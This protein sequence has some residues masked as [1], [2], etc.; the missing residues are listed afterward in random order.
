MAGKIVMAGK[1]LR[2]APWPAPSSM[3]SRRR[4]PMLACMFGRVVAMYWA[5]HGDRAGDP[6]FG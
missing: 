6:D 5:G 3:R 4:E 1:I 2:D